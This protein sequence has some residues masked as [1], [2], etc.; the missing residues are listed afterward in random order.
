[1]ATHVFVEDLSIAGIAAARE[2]YL[3]TDLR[4]R[5]ARYHMNVDSAF[6]GWNDIWL[7][8]ASC[9]WNIEQIV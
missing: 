5:L 1:M 2:A 9:A 6:W 4:E 7:N 8:P 3:K